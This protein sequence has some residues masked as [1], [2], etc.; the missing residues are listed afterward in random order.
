M[1]FNYLLFSVEV[2]PEFD[3]SIACFQ[4]LL[5]HFA[6][7]ELFFEKDKEALKIGNAI[8]SGERIAFADMMVSIFTSLIL[9]LKNVY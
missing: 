7:N 3:A 2:V 5:K 4:F 6:A 9:S 1:I 8:G